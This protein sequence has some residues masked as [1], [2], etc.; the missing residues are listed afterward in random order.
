MSI[1]FIENLTKKLDKEK[2]LIDSLS[3]SI[4]EEEFVILTGP[5]GSGKST[6]LSI[7]A[8]FEKP[9]EGIVQVL[10]EDLFSLQTAKKLRFRRDNIGFVSQDEKLIENLSIIENVAL[11]LIGVKESKTDIFLKASNIISY[12]GLEKK[13]NDF[14]PELSGAEKEL[15]LLCRALVKNPRLLLLDEPM[16]FLDHQT[17]VKVMTYLRQLAMD[18]QITVICSLA[19][20]RLYPFASRVIRMKNG[21][22]TDVLG[23]SFNDTPFLRI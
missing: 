17:G 3:L 10:G 13:K 12:M 21:K 7:L 22:I 14:P 8:G 16:K 1:V 6:L 9:T 15:A 2:L 18:H 20:V 5:P 23:E 19:D 11:P 4:E